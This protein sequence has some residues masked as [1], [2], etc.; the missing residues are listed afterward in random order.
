MA[1]NGT[2]SVSFRIEDG[3][4]GIRTL[5]A[6]AQALRRV[7]E[8]NARAADAMTRS[9]FEVA[10]TVTTINAFRDSISQ[11]SD[12]LTQLSG[13]GMSFSSAMRAANTMA[14][15]DAEGFSRLKDEVSELAKAVPVARDELANGL[16]QVIS[17]GVPEDNWISFLNASA[18]SSVGGIADLGQVVGVTSTMIK[19]YGLEWSAAA[20]IQDKI[21][22]TA[23]NGVTSFEALAQALPRVTGNAATLGVTIDELLGTFA[24]LT[25]VSGNT[26]EVSTQLAAIFTSLVKPNSE[27]TKMAEEMG[28]QFDAAAI[29]AAG[30]FQN[31]LASLDRSVKA[32]A[33]ASGTL[34]QE[35]YGRLFGS[36]EAL[37][38]L[39]PL[40]GELADNFTANIDNMVN[41]AG[42]MDA[43]F[44]DMSST[45]E[46]ATQMV[47]NQYGAFSDFFTQIKESA[48]PYLDFAANV[49]MTA[50][51][52][53][54]LA[55]SFKGLAT[56]Q[57]MLTV[58][59]KLL[60]ITL[61][62]VNGPVRNL[63]AAFVSAAASG[64]R[65]AVAVTAF[66]VALRG[67]LIT[68]GIGA[69]IWALGLAI[70][71]L[72][73]STDK[74]AQ[75]TGD[76][77]EAEEKAA[78]K[79]DELDQIRRKEA[80]TLTSVRSQLELN[81]ARLKDFKGT[82]QQEIKLVNQMNSA[83][84]ETM[85]YFSSVSD[86]YKTLVA[87]SEEYCKQM[88]AEA[89]TRLLADRIAQKELER[90]D[91]KYD[92][93]GNVR[94]Y[95]SRQW[96]VFNITD[97]TTEDDLQRWRDQGFMVKDDGV[98]TT[99]QKDLKQREY[100]QKGREIEALRKQMNAAVREASSIE[101]TRTGSPDRPDLGEGGNGKGGSGGGKSGT[102]TEL[103]EI[104]RIDA[105]IARNKEAALT[106][107]GAEL[108]KLR[109]NTLE[110]I[111]Q[112]DELRRRQDYISTPDAYTPPPIE[113]IKTYN[114]LHKALEYYRKELGDADAEKRKIIDGEIKKLEDLEEA[115]D[116]ALRP[117]TAAATDLELYI[118]QLVESS[119]AKFA[120]MGSPLD[121]MSTQELIDR[122][123][124][125]QAVLAG[126]DGDITE[127]Q[128]ESLQLAAE[129]YEKYISKSMRSFDTF[130]SA[131]GNISGITSGIEGMT[132][133]LK[134]N[135]SAWQ[136]ITSVI[137][138]F[139]QIYEGLKAL[140]DLIGQISGTT[141]VG[142]STQNIP[143]P[144][145]DP[146]AGASSAAAAP[147]ADGGVVSGPTHCLVAEYPGASS[148]PEVIA[149]L[150][151]LRTLIEPAGCGQVVVTGTLRGV[152][153][154]IVGVI[155]NETRIAGK[156]G[157]RSNIKI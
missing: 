47:R 45:G 13:D 22:L 55:K 46:A 116:N 37:R 36:A 40:Q 109:E 118:D 129:E 112:R 103:S 31:F 54:M 48:G 152:G 5:T 142:T 147:M 60:N 21:Q 64:G 39:T 108:E 76:L 149:P 3:Q 1:S 106:A 144:T 26:A 135:G 17:N 33:A 114:E 119:R 136:K 134:S 96:K 143:I 151:K 102:V 105:E 43:A 28:I 131:W 9:I 38:A 100:D 52:V 69:A 81:I 141:L 30:G 82:K 86:W 124:Q 145:P 51:S 6:D 140:I 153:R 2:I 137:N 19:N 68:S 88:V 98:Y 93:Y 126:M 58:R 94:K 127:K 84:G 121:G 78:R 92:E 73:G 115:W 79:A 148:N 16:Y 139:L 61:A 83:Y 10:A 8:E 75:S 97:M 27:A 34:E 41:S 44:A 117:P 66:K 128:R 113:E 157:K 110:L 155:A 77:T 72:V 29:K 18:R 104:A 67:L 107:T 35:V 123:R 80:D 24:T 85:G 49:F 132:D 138:A 90:H 23:R 4:D 53:G 14:G 91:L 7:F 74:A 11:V 42:T 56:T 89:S 57:F 150:D 125:I 95:D 154:E 133:A 62:A 50:A 130:K 101:Y 120:S 65:A 70:D 20:D 71:Y 111:R 99:S 156:S 32:Y 12:V 122:Y 59:T 25:G 15:K 63:R 87:N 146:G